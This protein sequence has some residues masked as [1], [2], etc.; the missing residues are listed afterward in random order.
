MKKIAQFKP[1]III[2]SSCQR[3]ERADILRAQNKMIAFR[4]NAYIARASFSMDD[5]GHGGCSMIVSSD[6]QILKD[7][8]NDVGKESLEIDVFKKY[9]RTA[10]FGGQMIRNDDFISNGLCPEAFKL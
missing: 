5:D 8:G 10:G 1:D 2:I 6:G 9:M 4:C 3:G 7:M